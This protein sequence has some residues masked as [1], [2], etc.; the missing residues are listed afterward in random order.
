MLDHEQRKYKR[1]FH[2][3]MSGI[4]RGGELRF[5]TLTSSTSSPLDI[6][7]SWRK[8]YMRMVRR[9]MITGYIKVTEITKSGLLHLHVLFRGSYV[10]QAWLSKVWSSIHG[11]EVVDIR[12]AYGKSGVG[13]Y[14]AKYMSKGGERYSWSYGWVYRGFAGVWM[15]A[16]RVVRQRSP[17]GDLGRNMANLLAFWRSHLRCRSSGV[18]WL[19]LVWAGIDKR[20]A[21]VKMEVSC[22]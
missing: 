16:K 18:G 21:A 14:M 8:L 9:Q 10:A 19:Q 13:R 7:R 20:P 22:Q 15:E 6:Q 1:C 4:E 17:A 2:R 3:V 11:A 5:L 12:K